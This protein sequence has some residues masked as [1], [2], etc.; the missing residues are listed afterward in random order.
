MFDYQV[1]NAEQI[2]SP[3]LIYYP[4][5][6]RRN[7]EKMVE[8]AG[9]A[10][11]LWPHVK[12]HKSANVVKLCQ[13]A[14][15]RRFKAAT[16]AEAEMCAQC[17]AEAVVLAYPLVGPNIERF[18][19][20]Q[21]VCP[22]TIFYAIHES[23]ACISKIAEAS[24]NHGLTTPVMLDVNSGM[25]RTG[26][27]L[28]AAL[29]VYRACAE[30]PGIRMCG[31][32][33]YDGHHVQL[34]LEE[35]VSSVRNTAGKLH[36]LQRAVVAEGL[37]EPIIIVAGTPAFPCYRDEQDFY[38]S[39]GCCILHDYGYWHNYSDL[40]FEPAALVLGRVISHPAVGMFTIDVAPKSIAADPEGL[41][42]YIIGWAE[43]IEL[44]RRNEEHTVFRMKEGSKRSRPDIDEVL[45]VIPT[46]ICP[47][48][49][50]YPSAVVVEKNVAVGEWAITARNRKITI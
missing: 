37:G 41:R 16:I 43:D 46:H 30:L 38:V 13:E 24:V 12:T 21:E 6:I 36:S 48:N 3:A 35:R 32:H 23:Y 42:G 50:L 7:L 26:V 1:K 10:E 45:Y 17:A 11:R 22:D 4:E 33:S 28:D 31:I 15:I 20:L 40:D 29:D 47:T 18:M 9:G 27:A 25:D 39:P 34:S 5:Q 14:G 44:V 8:L 19:K 49:A 2:A